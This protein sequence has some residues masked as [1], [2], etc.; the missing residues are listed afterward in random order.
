MTSPPC[1]LVNVTSIF[2]SDAEIFVV[3][4]L[5]ALIV[6]KSSTISGMFMII[7]SSVD[8]PGCNF[9]GYCDFK[10]NSPRKTSAI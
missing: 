6:I 3:A 2:S 8:I 5:Y 9:I 1:K 4:S 10:N 7:F